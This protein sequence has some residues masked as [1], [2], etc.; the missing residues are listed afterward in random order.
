MFESTNWV[1]VHFEIKAVTVTLVSAMTYLTHP[2]P[3]HSRSAADTELTVTGGHAKRGVQSF[4]IE[5]LLIGELRRIPIFRDQN[6]A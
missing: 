5:L 3:F 1:V 2:S 6:T 4:P